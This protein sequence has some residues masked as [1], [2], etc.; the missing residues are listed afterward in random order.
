MT[1]LGL[2]NTL[3]QLRMTGNAVAQTGADPS[4]KALVCV[5]LTGGNDS[6][7]MLV[8]TTSDEYS[9]Y[10]ASRSNL[11][12]PLPG[13]TNGVLPLNVLNTPGR[14]FGLNPAMPQLQG[15]FNTGAA[16]FIANTGTLIEPIPNVAGYRSGSFR[17]PQ[18]LFSHASQIMEWQTSLPQTVTGLNGWAGRMADAVNILNDSAGG[19]PMSISLD[20]N[21]ILQTGS[22]IVPYVISENGSIG[23]SG[24]GQ[25]PSTSGLR[26]SSVSSMME[27]SYRTI[28]ER[29]YAEGTSSSFDIHEAFSSATTSAS[30]NTT[31][32]RTTL[33]N[34]LAMVARSIKAAPDLGHKRQ[35]F[36]ITHGSF[37]H[38]SDLVE[39]QA[40]LLNELD[41]AMSA[42]NSAMHEQN[43]NDQVTLFTCSEFSRTLRSNGRGTDHGW[44]GNQIVMGGAVDGAKIHGQYPESLLIGSGQD[45]GTNGRLL[46]T[47]SCDLYFAELAKWFGVST[48]DLETI[49]PNLSNFASSP[50]LEFIQ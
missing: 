10:S 24:A 47:T 38:H 34:K 48:G 49:L 12:L 26:A 22:E 45:I 13:S 17:T 18:A 15:L 1:S 7:N 2:L 42:F 30:L 33:A 11:A 20:G 32:P 50:P 46:P 28:L 40:L 27:Q 16:G 4:F 36:F 19:V 5:F 14:T 9:D 25:G 44:G 3:L 23:L 29:A 21:N 37:D 43:M 35:I 6:F 39:P 41:G 31:F 8:P